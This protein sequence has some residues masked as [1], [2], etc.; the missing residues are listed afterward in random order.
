MRHSCTGFEAKARAATAA[1]EGTDG[2]MSMGWMV[3]VAPRCTFAIISNR[4]AGNGRE[5]AA[6][7]AREG[8]M[9]LIIGTTGAQRVCYSN[10]SKLE[11]LLL[12][13]LARLG[14]GPCRADLA[15]RWRV[16]PPVTQ[17]MHG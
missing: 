1:T 14:V 6:F 11:E 16:Q 7:A 4:S 15:R 13:L 2:G 5:R 10:S 9:L 8:Q 12:L 3:Y 17:T